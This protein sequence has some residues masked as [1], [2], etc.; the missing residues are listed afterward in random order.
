ME[1][2]NSGYLLL[3][4]LLIPYLLWYFLCGK[5]KEPTIKMSD[6]F[7]YQHISKSW[8]IR[9][10]HLPMFLRC[11]VYTLVVIVLARPQTYNSWDNKDAEGI[12]IMLTM[13]ISASMLTE[14]VFPNRIEVAKEVASDF[15]SGRPNDNIGL[16]IFAGEAFTQCPMTVDHAALLNLLHNVRTDLVV[17]GLIQDGTA[18]GM[19]LANSVSRLK[20]S[21]AKSKVIIL[22]TDGSNNVGSIS[23]MTAASIAKKYGIRIYTIGLGKESEGDLGA[24]DYKTL[25]NIAVSTNGEFYRAQSQ[26]ELSKIYQDIDKLEKTKLRVKAYSHLHEAYMPFAW[27]ALFLFCLDL[28]LLLTV[29]RR[30]P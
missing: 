24:I 2:A 22:L 3:L 9:M 27:L 19:G 5:G 21:K 13:D 28:L 29:F 4:I 20:D 12:D 17:K 16:T 8:R 25:Q 23:P 30:L 14:D 26:A 6:T 11:L 15:I 7:A 10:I 1:F 18:I